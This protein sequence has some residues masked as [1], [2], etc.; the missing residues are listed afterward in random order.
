MSQLA[1]IY[2]DLDLVGSNVKWNQEDIPNYENEPPIKIVLG[3][4]ENGK[5]IWGYKNEKE[6]VGKG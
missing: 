6:T 3:Y 4:D 2:R 1:E 5:P